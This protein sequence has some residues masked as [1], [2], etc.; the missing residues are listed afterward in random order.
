MDEA[1]LYAVYALELLGGIVLG[2]LLMDL[3]SRLRYH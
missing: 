2:W 1:C 3:Y